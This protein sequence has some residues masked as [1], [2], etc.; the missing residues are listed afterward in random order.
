MSVRK[1]QRPIGWLFVMPVVVLVAFNALIPLM[2]VVNYSVQ[3]T[4][5]NDEFFWV[6]WEWFQE[7]LRSERFAD[8]LGRQVLFTTLVLLIER[9]VDNSRI[10]E[11]D[12]NPAGMATG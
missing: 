10:I 3:D 9:L 5:G 12:N 7:V 2:T 8:A 1:K 6:G 4:F 11:P